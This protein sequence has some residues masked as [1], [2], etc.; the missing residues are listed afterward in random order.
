MSLPV[1]ANEAE[2]LES[3][4]S[5]AVLDSAPEIAY[6]ELGELAAQICGCSVSYIGMMDDDRLWLKAKYGLP[7]E[8]TQCPREISFCQ[9][10]ICGVEMVLAPDLAEDP[11]FRD[12]PFVTGP[13]N[14]RFYCGMP[15]ITGE[16]YALGTLCVMDFEPRQLTSDQLSAV[17]RLA[18]QVMT[19]LELRRKVVEL[20]Q[21]HAEAGAAKA[22][23]DAL[24]A[25][26][27]PR[28]IAEELSR[29]QRV[30]PRYLPSVTI[31]FADCKGFTLLA[32][33]VEPAALLGLLDQYFSIFD[34]VVAR[35]GLEKIKTVGDAYMAVA[36][37]PEARRQHSIDACLAALELQASLA[38]TN[39]QR[40]KLRLPVLEVRVG[41]HAGPVIAGVVGKRRFTYDIW[42]DSVN[43]AAQMEQ[44]GEPGRVNVSGSVAAEVGSLFEL[45][46]RGTVQ[47]KHKGALEMFWLD[48]IRPALARDAEGRVP[49]A[50]F[51]AERERLRTGFSG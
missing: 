26:I 6:D 36:G 22:R 2:R 43:V 4:R 33:R 25:D 9:H 20:D 11:R 18:R 38:R 31:L 21:A 48:R 12:L 27:L 29:D 24:L 39:A 34:E 3:L 46:P 30:A 40:V 17:R 28:S 47:A 14:F 32:E 19:Q 35:H 13:P 49:N 23:A 5:F 15:L 10:T 44:N 50:A 42:G 16:G 37:A 45:A 51:Q 41:L 7:P 8:M 1:P